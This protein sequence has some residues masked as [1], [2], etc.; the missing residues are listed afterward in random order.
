MFVTRRVGQRGVCGVTCVVWTRIAIAAA[1]HSGVAPPALMV[2][3]GMTALAG[4][5][6]VAFLLTDGFAKCGW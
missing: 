2:G 4:V 5:F 3:Y 6:A 1:L